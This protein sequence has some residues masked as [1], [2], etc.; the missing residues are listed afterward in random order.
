[1]SAN[2]ICLCV[3]I[4][5]GEFAFFRLEY[6]DW[7]KAFFEVIPKRKFDKGKDSN[8]NSP[9]AAHSDQESEGD[10]ESTEKHDNP[11]EREPDYQ[12]T[13]VKT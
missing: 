4:D 11:E 3:E 2:D 9:F 5:L 10:I 7:E 1:M 12:A 6:R 13:E 8:D